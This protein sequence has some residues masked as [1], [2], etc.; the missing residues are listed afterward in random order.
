MADPDRTHSEKAFTYEDLARCAQHFLAERPVI[1]LGTGATIP[2]GLPSMSELADLLLAAIKGN[3]PGWE[4]FSAR[5][6]M[7]KDLEQ[8][9][10]EVALP[11]ETVEI[12]VAV[13]WE[14]ISL[15]D[16][17]FY[18]Q[19]LK[20]PVEF[21]LAALFKYLLRTADSHIQVV[22]TNYDRL[23]EYAANYVNAYVSTGVTAGW[24]QR[25]V[26]ASVNAE[27]PPA[28]G[29]DGQVSLLKVHGS[30]DWFRDATDDVVGVPL[31]RAIPTNTQ[32]LVVTPGVTKYRAV[33]KDPFRTVI[34]AADAVLRGASCY[35]CVGYG[36]NDEHIQPI[37]VNRVMKSDIPLVLVTKQ[38]T[39]PTHKAFLRKPPKKF[40]FLEE[41]DGGTTV[42]NPEY[43]S[44]VRLDGVSVW[45]LDNFMRL[46]IGEKAR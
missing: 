26:P 10:N 35:V 11:E 3:P 27:H 17:E 2:H 13:T 30:L 15:R 19:L 18:E 33:H 8:A 32:P 6:N 23:A 29:Y 39:E 21:P 36:F 16:L 1:V 4:E 25:F 34:T 38:L 20:G 12:L 5:L 9:L 14:I 28:P 43:P 31:A 45:R 37:L 40:I 22:T 7:T 42:Y 41:A 44:G 24:L 46:I